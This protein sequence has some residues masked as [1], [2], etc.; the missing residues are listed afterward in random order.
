MASDEEA[1]KRITMK[2]NEIFPVFVKWQ[3]L[4]SGMVVKINIFIWKKYPHLCKN[5][6]NIVIQT[7]SLF[8]YT[9]IHTYIF[10]LNTK[11]AVGE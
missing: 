5:N 6:I 7:Y 4:Q 8:C 2:V 3:H 1:W 11:E 10:V 9:Y